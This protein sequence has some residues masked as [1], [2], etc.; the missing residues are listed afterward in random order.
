MIIMK[1]EELKNW[2]EAGKIEYR[3][4]PFVLNIPDNKIV[5]IAAAAEGT[6]FNEYDVSTHR[7]YYIV[8]GGKDGIVEDI[9]LI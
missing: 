2:T 4:S 5:H 8:A 3:A 9:V 6:P 1:K 7:L